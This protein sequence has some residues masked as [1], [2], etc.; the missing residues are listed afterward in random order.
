MFAIIQGGRHVDYITDQ[1][2]SKLIENVKKKDKKGS[3]INIKPF[4]VKIITFQNHGSNFLIIP[5]I[6][7]E[8]K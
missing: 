5:K 6:K 4:Q 7:M 3:G 1:V 2:V 8:E